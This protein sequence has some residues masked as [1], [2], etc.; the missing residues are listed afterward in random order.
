VKSTPNPVPNSPPNRVEAVQH[1]RRMRGGAQSHLM[2]CSDGNFYVVKFRNNPQHQRVLANEMLATS[3]GWKARLPVPPAAIVEVSEWLIANTPELHVQLAHETIP[4]QAGLQFGSQYVVSPWQGRVFD[5][6]PPEMYG[7]VRNVN[8]FAGILVLDKWLGNSD[9][10]QAAFW[11]RSTERK[12]HAAF[13]DHGY[14]FNAGEWTFPDYPLRGIY[15]RNEVYES[16]R[17]WHSFQPWL[18]SIENMPE[19]VL[20]HAATRI[21]S[22]WY[23]DEWNALSN[24]VRCLLERRSIVRDLIEQFRISPRRPFPS[25]TQQGCGSGVPARQTCAV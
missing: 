8:E 1:I 20:W 7:L 24:L 3:L 11:Q 6:L 21:P 5:Y 9:G 19:D 25:W 4:C 18:S 22:C 2:R 23:G 14:C 13:I 10:R 15:A 17:G 16:V 12:Y